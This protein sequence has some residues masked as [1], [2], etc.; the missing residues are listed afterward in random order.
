MLAQGIQ[1]I[2]YGDKISS[3]T[4]RFKELIPATVDEISFQTLSNFPV[5]LSV[6]FAKAGIFAERVSIGDTTRKN[7]AKP[8]TS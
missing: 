2:D 6:R 8:P 1:M 3:D 4:R 5:L 7:H